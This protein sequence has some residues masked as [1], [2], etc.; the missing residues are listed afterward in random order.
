ML[1]PST[2]IAELLTTGKDF[3]LW[4]NRTTKKWQEFLQDWPVAS[5]HEALE[6]SETLSKFLNA[7]DTAVL[8]FGLTTEEDNDSCAILLK[9][10]P[11]AKNIICRT[12]EDASNKNITKARKRIDFRLYRLMVLYQPI[13]EPQLLPVC[14]KSDII[15]ISRSTSNLNAAELLNKLNK[16]QSRSNNWWRITHDYVKTTLPV[17]ADLDLEAR[18][19]DLATALKVLRARKNIVLQGAPGCGKTYGIPEIVTRLCGVLDSDTSRVNVIKK[20]KELVGSRVFFTTFHPSLDYEDFVE[21]YK[22]IARTGD[23]APS[24]SSANQGEFERRDGI[25]LLACAA[26]LNQNDE[27]A[28]DSQKSDLPRLLDS[29]PDARACIY[30]VVGDKEA[31]TLSF[32]KLNNKDKSSVG[33]IRIE[34]NTTELGLNFTTTEEVNKWVRARNRDEDVEDIE[35]RNLNKFFTNPKKGQFVVS[36]CGPKRIDAIGQVLDNEITVHTLDEAEGR[37]V[38]TRPVQWFFLSEDSNESTEESSEGISTEPYYADKIFRQ[39][40]FKLEDKIPVSTLKGILSER[41]LIDSTAR[42]KPVVLI[43]DEINRGNIAK[44]FGELITLIEADKR[45]DISVMLP[46]SRTQFTV[47]SNLYIIGTMNTADRSVGGI[48]YAL[49][50]RFAFVRVRP[51]CLSLKNDKKDPCLDFQVE[52]FTA[53]SQL[54]IEELPKTPEFPVKRNEKYLSEAYN[55]EDV[56][57]GHSYFVTN[58]RCDIGYRW[59]YEIR[60]LLEEYI[61]DGVLKPEAIEAIDTIEKDY[62]KA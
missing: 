3:E 2:L 32:N 57:P 58:S 37:Y 60:P 38:L 1:M 29:G 9:D 12:A 48:D 30:N 5:L 41:N 45:G 44:I 24:G 28:K 10:D 27:K 16:N 11:D 7:V 22:P 52:L 14:S 49:R 8:Q 18:D 23:D 36:F 21:G 6:D 4:K 42:T 59:R 26:A 33:T 56:W 54:F 55:P 47:P 20:Y 40:F 61:R 62:V 50:R 31:Q 46:Y 39:A 13:E 34:I 51:H 25:F 53:V 17:W 35:N 15:R 19:Y 43:I